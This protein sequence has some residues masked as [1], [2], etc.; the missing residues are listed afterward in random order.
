[1]V[2]A[3][4]DKLAQQWVCDS[5][6][7]HNATLLMDGHLQPTPL[8]GEVEERVQR[9]ARRTGRTRTFFILE[10]IRRY[11]DDINDLH[12]AEQRLINLRAG[13]SRVVRLKD[14]MEPYCME[15]H[16]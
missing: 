7:V 5:P 11:S 12:V 3:W 9:L 8:S 15:D 1:M 4:R 6:P 16:A 13:R 2:T 14:V 10:A